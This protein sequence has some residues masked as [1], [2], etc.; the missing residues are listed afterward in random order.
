[1]NGPGLD[2]AAGGHVGLVA[3]GLAADAVAD[4]DRLAGS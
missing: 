4:A 2:E 1:L 3:D